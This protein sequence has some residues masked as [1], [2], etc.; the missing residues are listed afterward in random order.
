LI[1]NRTVL[2][3]GDNF[4]VAIQREDGSVTT[5][6]LANE[7]GETDELEFATPIAP[8]T[9][10][11]ALEETEYRAGSLV[12]VGLLGQEFKRFK[13]SSIDPERNLEFS[14]TLVDEAPGLVRTTA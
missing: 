8:T 11:F 7:A 3:D 10:I 13:L 12:T 1:L 4:G 2:L 5:H 6:A 9:A 14:L